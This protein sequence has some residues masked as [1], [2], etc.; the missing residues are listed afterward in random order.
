MGKKFLTG[1]LVVLFMVISFG[2]LAHAED[3]QYVIGF[4]Y[5]QQRT[6][7]NGKTVN[8]VAVGMHWNDGSGMVNR[9]VVEELK[10]YRLG[11]YPEN[12][13]ELTNV[14]IQDGIQEGYPRFEFTNLV[15]TWWFS[16]W[17]ASNYYIADIAEE[18]V[19]GTIYQ[20]EVLCDDGNY[21]DATVLFGEPANLPVV[22]SKSF[23][24]EFDEDGNFYFHWDVPKDMFYLGPELLNRRPHVRAMINFYN[25]G[26]LTDK[27]W[28]KIPY[29]MSGVFI[30][31]DWG[32]FDTEAD[33]IEVGVEVRL[34]DSTYRTYSDYKELKRIP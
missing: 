21:Y 10:L 20:I 32:I 17:R 7:E 13:M 28:V 25:A 19:P 4:K 31:V 3:P 6:F 29:L 2:G 11:E 1:I 27:I 14:V 22:S 34:N 24:Y 26:V 9:N 12:P 23:K 33:Y 30:P 16:G 15:S 18:L 8:R 5:V